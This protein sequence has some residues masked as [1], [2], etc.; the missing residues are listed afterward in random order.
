M[1]KPN[2]FSHVTTTSN[3]R[4]NV[5]LNVIW[6]R[7]VSVFVRCR[8]TLHRLERNCDDASLCV[9]H[10][11]RI[12]GPSRVS[13]IDDVIQRTSVRNEQASSDVIVKSS[14]VGMVLFVKD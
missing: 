5:A 11:E 6:C 14:V 7:E 13:P 12:L 9:D 3:L 4:E 2:I 8:N 10:P 1:M